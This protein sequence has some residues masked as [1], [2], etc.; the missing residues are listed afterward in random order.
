MAK[1]DPPHDRVRKITHSLPD[2]EEGT[3]HGFPAYRVAG[4]VFVWFPK[5]KEVE[6]DSLGARMAITER[7]RRIDTNPDAYYVTPH[8][9]DYPA[10]LVRVWELS[11]AELR[12]LVK[13]AYTFVTATTT[14]TTKTK[15]AKKARRK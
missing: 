5:K 15:T 3:T 6:T 7:S 12:E 1:T 14:K 8:Y 9:E 13:A 11:D 10:V 2:V 4:K